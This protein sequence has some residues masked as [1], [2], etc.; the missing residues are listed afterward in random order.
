MLQFFKFAFLIGSARPYIPQNI[1]FTT[2][3]YNT[4][5]C[6]M[7][8]RTVTMKNM[9]YD[10]DTAKNGFPNCCNQLLTDVSLFPNA[11]FNTC[12]PFVI[13]NTSYTSISYQCS[14][15]SIDGL[16]NT[17]RLAYVGII[18]LMLLAVVIMIS[19]FVGLYKCC[20]SR[21]GYSGL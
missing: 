17:E 14:K 13:P 21:N 8:N 19:V 11:S 16:N 3:F 20:C 9:C 7:V 18:S 15:T 6:S 5:N 10:T 4:S 1:D 2:N 12:L